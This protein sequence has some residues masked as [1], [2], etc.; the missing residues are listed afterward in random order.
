MSIEKELEIRC[1]KK[2]ELCESQD[3]LVVYNVPPY[4]DDN[5]DK[6]VMICD[7]CS[8]KLENLNQDDAEYWTCVK[9]TMWSQVPAV[10][11]LIWRIL[12]NFKSENWAQSLLDML[13]LDEETMKWA[14]HASSDSQDNSSIRH[15]DSN[16]VEL[17][18]GDTVVIDKDLKVKGT[19]I[20]AK[21][22]T[23]VRGIHLVPNNPDQIEG[24]VNGQ[25]IVILTKFVSKS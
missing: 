2:C 6:C 7:T 11:V 9:N 24:R 16:G 14:D 25:M 21:R 23:A 12:N 5:I 1:N 13:Y 15:L 4:L 20:T 22:G 10:Q 8:E 17:Q 19:S 18:N 3:N